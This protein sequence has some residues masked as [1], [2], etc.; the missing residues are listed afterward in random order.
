MA[1]IKVNADEWNSLTAEDR[2]KIT[3]IM[4]ENELLEEDE[5][6]TPDPDTPP[7]S[8]DAKGDEQGGS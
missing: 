3:E 2:A 6:I 5:E 7:S 1:P 4:R 8:A